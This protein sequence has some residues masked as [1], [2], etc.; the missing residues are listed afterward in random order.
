MRDVGVDHR[1]VRHTCVRLLA[2]AALQ[3]AVIAA[4]PGPAFAA[5]PDSPAAALAAAATI[6]SGSVVPS[7]WT[8]SIESCTVGTESAA[9]LEATLQAVNII[10]SAAGVGPVTFDPALNQKALAAALMMVAKGELS[11]YPDPGWPCSTTDGVTAAARSNLYIGISGAAAMLGYAHD[12]GVS[13]LGHRRWL[14][15]PAATVFGSGSTGPVAGAPNPGGSNALWVLAADGSVPTG[16]VAP[17]TRV[18]WPPAGHV[19][20]DWIPSKWSLTIG[21]TGQTVTV[22]DPQVTMSLDGDPV[23]VG[24]VDYMGGGYGPGVQIGWNPAITP[25]D[26]TGPS[27][28][29]QV[30]ITGISVDGTPTPIDYTVHVDNAV[31]EKPTGVVAEL[32]GNQ[33]TVSWAAP[34][35]NGGTSLTGYTVTANPGG[36]SCTTSVWWSVD[37]RLP[38]PPRTCQ[39]AALNYG[40]SYTFTVTAT[41][42]AGTSAPSTQSNAITPVAPVPPARR[43]SPPT[44]VALDVAPDD[45]EGVFRASLT[46]GPPVDDGGSPVTG[47]RVTVSDGRA[48][49][50]PAQEMT[51]T[52]PW[53]D[54][55]RAYTVSVQ[56]Q[57]LKGLSDPASVNFATPTYV[58][59]DSDADGIP[60]SGDMCPST[61]GAGSSTGCPLPPPIGSQSPPAGTPAAGSPAPAPAQHTHPSGAGPF[62]LRAGQEHKRQVE[63]ARRREPQQGR[64]LLDVPGAA[65]GAI[66][67]VEAAEDLQDQ[68]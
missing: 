11:H 65:A 26:L 16:T 66:R 64:G 28:T 22:T 34:S 44:A 61:P 43:P 12:E 47:Y 38:E 56:A 25:S 32:T 37:Y 45:V 46:W 23:S 59:V 55:S 13:S 19:T 36:S 7:G 1:G 3:V 57:N 2:L 24:Y 30:A 4:P 5:A 40:T 52:I 33:A 68:G 42:D 48:W 63:A 51:K 54:P 41:N 35:S 29:I 62:C 15:N 67:C 60:D 8:G 17:G 14:L 10:R 21:G 9:S 27:H 20:P 31:P 50:L 53:L 58:P 6:Q 18:S 49:S 39:I